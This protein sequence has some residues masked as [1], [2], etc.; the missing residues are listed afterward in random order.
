[1]NKFILCEHL[2]QNIINGLGAIADTMKALVYNQ[3]PELFE[4]LDFDRDHIFLEPLLF[5][6]FTHENRDQCA[7]L[8]Q[9]LFGYLDRASCPTRI[10]VISADNGVIHLPRIGYFK[11]GLRNAQLDLVCESGVFRLEGD[12]ENVAYAFEDCLM[13]ADGKI[14]VYHYNHPL[15]KPQYVPYDPWAKDL[16]PVE[17]EVEDTVKRHL[18]SLEKAL[19]LLKR[20]CRPLYDEI[21]ATNRSITLF[22]NPDVYCFVTLS[23]HGAIFL[24]TIPENDEV[25]FLEELIHQCSHNAFNAAL[26]DKGAYFNIDVEHEMLGEH[27]NKKNET[28]TLY[29]AL[30]GLYTVVKRYECFEVLY[31]EDVF[32][33]RQKHEFLGR[34]GDIKKRLN[35]GL[36][37]LDFDKVYTPKEVEIYRLMQHTGDDIATRLKVL[38]GV[39]DFSNQ[40]D[41]FSYA[42]FSE[43]NPLDRFRGI[44][45]HFPGSG[46]QT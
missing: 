12:G 7:T 33:G 15:F 6:Y 28:R 27:L 40:P 14:E 38:D 25:F 9:L 4:F 20:Y 21:L 10:R 24:T 37:G 17:V 30:H 44:E 43:L 31:H 32:S 18:P 26:F 3:A 8:Q 42:K 29:S 45:G 5:A 35:T 23:I 39:F 13:V 46:P 16:P 36:D 1:M 2:Q 19:A 11:T 34:I 22:H 41:E